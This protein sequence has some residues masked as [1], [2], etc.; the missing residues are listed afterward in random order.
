MPDQHIINRANDL[1]EQVNFH[2]YRYHTLDSP[3]VSDSEYD[4]LLRELQ[5]LEEAQPELITPE[6]PTQ[7][8]GTTPSPEF[9]E[10]QHPQPMLS[11][12]NAFDDQEMEAWH[13]RGAAMLETDVFAMVCEPK[14][15]G[16][17]IALTY[18]EGR[19]VRG[20]TRG[21]GSRGEDVTPNIRTIPTIPMVLQRSS[22]VPPR[23]E[24]RGEVFFPKDGFQRLNEERAERGEALM[25]NPRN[26]AAGSLRQLD[27]RITARP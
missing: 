24:V 21:D 12:S 27:P 10:V 6:S 8:V 2:N 11:L 16:L 7:R 17:A 1:R 15:D 18:E 9:R 14:I 20:A 4:A 3:V 22:S 19:L 5:S 23:L 13:R 26:A 25:A